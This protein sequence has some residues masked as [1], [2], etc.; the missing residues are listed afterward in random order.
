MILLSITVLIIFA[1]FGMPLFAVMGGLGLMAF[2][3]EEIATSAVIVEIYRLTSSPTL[4]TIPLFTFAGFVLAESQA[5]KRLLN[6]SNSLLGWLP[7]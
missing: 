4:V 5:T 3:L 2:H 6:L 1:L 7:G